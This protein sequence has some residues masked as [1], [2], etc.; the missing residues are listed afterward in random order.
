MVQHGK[1]PKPTQCDFWCGNFDWAHKGNTCLDSC[2]KQSCAFRYNFDTGNG[3]PIC[4]SSEM[5]VCI[6][7]QLHLHHM[8]FMLAQTARHT[9]M[10]LMPLSSRHCWRCLLHNRMNKTRA[11]KT[12]R[13]TDPATHQNTNPMNNKLDLSS[14]YAQ[15]FTPILN[16]SHCHMF[17]TDFS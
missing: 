8:N 12:R 10:Q 16:Y 6:N 3:S 14:Y 17:P 4:S 9:I 7:M 2:I 13:T 15:Q 1:P 11:P 5:K